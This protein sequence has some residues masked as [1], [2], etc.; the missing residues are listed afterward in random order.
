VAARASSIITPVVFFMVFSPLAPGTDATRDL[1][2]NPLD[3]GPIRAGS[4]DSRSRE[5]ADESIVA[6]AKVGILVASVLAGVLGSLA[7]HRSLPAG[8]ASRD[9]DSDSADV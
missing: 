7:L 5:S 6:S 1:I 9:G 3:Q 4:D 2:A 8:A